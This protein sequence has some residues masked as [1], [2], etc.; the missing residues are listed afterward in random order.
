MKGIIKETKKEETQSTNPEGNFYK[1][2]DISQDAELLTAGRKIEKKKCCMWKKIAGFGLMLTVFKNVINNFSDI[3]VKKVP[4]IHPVPFLLYRSIISLSVTM[5][6]GI[7]KDQPPFPSDQT[8][9][10]RILI[11]A[12]GVIACVNVLAC[13]Y[14]LLQ[15]PLAIQRMIL[16]TR[17]VFT[18]IFARIFLKESCGLVYLFSIL[19]MLSG[20][21]LAL[22]PSFLFGEDLKLGP[23]TGYTDDWLT[24]ALLLFLSTA[25]HSNVNIILRQLRKQHVVS[26][27]S[28][29]DIIYIIITFIGIICGG[30]EIFTPSWEDR[31]KI[32]FVSFSSITTTSLN[33]IALKIEEA[34]KITLIDRSS[35]L[36]IG[37]ISQILIFN[38]IPDN[39][40]FVGLFLVLVSVFLTGLY[41]IWQLRKE[42]HDESK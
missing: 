41:R 38:D 19:L 35:A 8:L 3:I 26:L 17:P 7:F 14:A 2:D 36:V 22:R 12:R 23:E 42:K 25:V 16:S 1:E 6:I 37:L 4:G 21:V 13:Y 27:N 11:V 40:T 30:I 18:L 24:A 32:C 9:R 20:L 31:L 5:T 10:D 15:M 28:S 29:R 33:I 34:G 39:L